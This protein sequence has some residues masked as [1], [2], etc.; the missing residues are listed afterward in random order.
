MPPE[1]IPI[2]RGVGD[3]LTSRGPGGLSLDQLFVRYRASALLRADWAPILDVFPDLLERAEA[4]CRDRA[5]RTLCSLEGALA[6][7]AVEPKRPN[8]SGA[9]SEAVIRALHIVLGQTGVV[10]KMEDAIGGS[11][12]H[13]RRMIRSRM[14]R[15]S[16]RTD[17]RDD[18]DD[19]VAD[20][21]VRFLED[22]FPALRRLSELGNQ[23]WWVTNEGV[24]AFKR[25][26]TAQRRFAQTKGTP[27]PDD[28][29]ARKDQGPAEVAELRDE[30]EAFERG[31]DDRQRALLRCLQDELPMSEVVSRFG[32]SNATAYRWVR[33]LRAR[34]KSFFGRVVTP[35]DTA[36]GMDPAAE[37][38]PQ[39]TGTEQG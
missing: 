21:T 1:E 31:L 28:S 25:K 5:A 18:L 38:A 24:N 17:D 14:R 32:V 36:P 34:T 35:V 26:L 33:D 39:N 6:R 12:G 19:V 20:A 29:A 27:V 37:T 16:Y 30:V 10:L 7:H 4:R 9:Q 15:F 11:L 23:K 13:L 2:R 3:A 8:G 22:P